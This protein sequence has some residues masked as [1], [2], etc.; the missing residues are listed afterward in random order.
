MP[1][2]AVPRH[3]GVAV[4][5]RVDNPRMRVMDLFG[6]IGFR[7]GRHRGRPVSAEQFDQDPQEQVERLVSGEFGEIGVE[8]ELRPSRR[9]TGIA[10]VSPD[11]G[12]AL[13]REKH[14]HIR[15]GPTLHDLGDVIDFDGVTDQPQILATGPAVLQ[16]EG[17]GV[18]LAC[19]CGSVTISP[20]PG[21][22]PAQ[23]N[24]RPP[25]LSEPYS[26]EMPVRRVPVSPRKAAVTAS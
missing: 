5:D 25:E 9:L 6:V 11:L 22:G 13:R 10:L 14:R 3:T 20:P 2:R 24:N 19:G 15:I 4:E 21:P 26:R 7:H 17:D 12:A 18:T 1:A 16:V 8:E 23:E